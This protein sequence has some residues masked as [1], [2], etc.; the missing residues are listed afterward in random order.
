MIQKT[1]NEI[2]A[3]L[4]KAKLDFELIENKALNDYLQKLFP[5]CPFNEEICTT[6]QCIECDVY[7]DTNK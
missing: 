2:R 1:T 4:S 6:N 7:K 5:S 3:L